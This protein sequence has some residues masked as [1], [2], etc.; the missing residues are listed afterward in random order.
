ME[1][2]QFPIETNKYYY[3]CMNANSPNG[4]EWNEM[5]KLPIY[6]TTFYMN[7][8]NYIKMFPNSSYML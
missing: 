2:F 7:K 4:M 6:F 8:L 3:F 5:N 1:V